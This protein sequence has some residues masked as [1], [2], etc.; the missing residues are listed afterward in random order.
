MSFLFYIVLATGCLISKDF[1][2]SFDRNIARPIRN[3]SKNLDDYDKFQTQEEFY[4]FLGN[5][6]TGITNFVT[7]KRE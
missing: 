5:L 7:F 4:E 2:Y 1:R 6:G 3:Y